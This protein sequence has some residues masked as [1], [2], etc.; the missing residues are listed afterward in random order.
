[1]VIV[2]S[3]KINTINGPKDIS[4]ITDK[5]RLIDRYHRPLPIKNIE[6][7]AAKEIAIVDG[8]TRVDTSTVFITTTGE[9][10]IDQLDSSFSSL[11]MNKKIV[12]HTFTTSNRVQ[13]GY[14][15]YPTRNKQDCF[16]NGI[17]V[18]L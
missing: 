16:V 13:V 17:N 3:G 4:Q 9:H 11:S 8:S 6:R 2:V 10:S 12:N 7:V 15:I 5:D 1:M 18:R 14:V